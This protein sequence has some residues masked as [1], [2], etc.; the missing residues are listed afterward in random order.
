MTWYWTYTSFAAARGVYLEDLF[1]RPQHRGKGYG[2]NLLAHLARG[3]VAAAAS[4][5]EWSVLTWNR[6]SIEF[7]EQLGARQPDDWFI[8][9][10]SGEALSELART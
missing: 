4:R 3:A 7:Y 9:R 5:I 8:Y 2:K 6:P 10:L 1:V